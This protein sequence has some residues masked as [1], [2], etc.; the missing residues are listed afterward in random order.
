MRA[1]DLPRVAAIA[2]EIHTAHPEDDA[3]LVER[4]RLYAAGCHVLDTRGAVAGYAI[5]HPWR[6][7]SP[8]AL[9]TRLKRIPANADTYYLHDVAIVE[10]ARRGGAASEIVATLVTHARAAGFATMTLIC[11]NDTGAF[12]SRLGFRATA[13]QA[14]RLRLET[15]GNDARLMVRV[16]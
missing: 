12:W 16:L 14:L 11:V 15:Y 1:S 8:P 5:S 7:S 10:A 2:A 4:L 13:D 6:R 9:N 3:V